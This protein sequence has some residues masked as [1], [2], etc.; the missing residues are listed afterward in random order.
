MT[1]FKNRAYG[2]VVIKAINSNYNADFSGQH[3]T[4]WAGLCY[5]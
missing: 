2:F 3:F 4:Q 1:E 5:R